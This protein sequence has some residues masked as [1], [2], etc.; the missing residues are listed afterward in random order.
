VIVVIA[1][2]GIVEEDEAAGRIV[3]EMEGRG[4]TAGIEGERDELERRGRT[5]RG[6]MVEMEGRR[7]RIES[8]GGGG[9]MEMKREGMAEREGME[10]W[11]RN[12]I[13]KRDGIERD[14][15]TITGRRGI[16]I[17]IDMKEGIGRED[18]GVMAVELKRRM[19]R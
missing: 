19:L 7:G 16:G 11:R 13:G 12:R 3:A 10:W 5:E 14:T 8:I 6:G 4:E 1:G 18:A 9:S 17:D 2:I 15:D